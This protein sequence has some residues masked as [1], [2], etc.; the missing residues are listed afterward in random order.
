MTN[1]K[2]IVKTKNKIYYNISPELYEKIFEKYSNDI[3][4]DVMV[5]VNYTFVAIWPM[6]GQL[7]DDL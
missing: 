3:V 1:I 7:M 2:T 5:A 4:N 6:R